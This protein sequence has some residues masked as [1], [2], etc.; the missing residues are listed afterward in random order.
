[1]SFVV[2]GV[3]AALGSWLIALIVWVP[4]AFF[5]LL[6]LIVLIGS[7]R[8]FRIALSEQGL[9]VQSN[10][11]R[12]SGPWS[13]VDGIHV[14]QTPPAGEP[15]RARSLLVLWLADGV[16]MR[17]KPTYPFGST[18]RKG[19]VIAELDNVRETPDEVVQALRRYAGE[20]F[21]PVH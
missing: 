10:G 5:F 19:Y 3:F 4:G 6:G 21:R 13:Q 16:P 9:E 7:T 17:Q 12:F 14:E 18:G 15:P 2:G 8:P 20:R 11:Y 1:M